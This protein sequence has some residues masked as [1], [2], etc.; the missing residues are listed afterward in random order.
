MFILEA[1]AIH[2][3]VGT[4]TSEGI[5]ELKFDQAPTIVYK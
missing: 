2:T 4:Q 5:V 1:L 3:A